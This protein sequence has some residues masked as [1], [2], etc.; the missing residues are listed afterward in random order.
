[1]IVKPT[2]V[3]SKKLERDTLIED[4]N[5][6]STVR[7]RSD[8]LKKDRKAAGFTQYAFSAACRSVSLSTVRRAEQGYRVTEPAAKKMAH[9]LDQPTNRYIIK[10]DDGSRADYVA[11][12]A[13]DWTCFHVDAEQNA[14]PRLALSEMCIRQSGG[15]IVGEIVNT[16]SEN[17]IAVETFKAEVIN[18]VV[19]GRAFHLGD[20]VSSG[21][22][23]ICCLA[24]RNDG[25]L[26]GYFS[27]INQNGDSVECMR[28]IAVRNRIPNFDQYVLE[29]KLIADREISLIHVKKLLEAGYEIDDA[30]VMLAALKADLHLVSR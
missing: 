23:A 8:V 19:S 11:W 20:D 13:G 9:I 3:I 25:W 15:Q 17:R 5:P 16:T 10:P 14:S 4:N 21:V 18:N 28:F 2:Q 26:D 7:I 29:A 27:R 22:G 24:K 1:M 6:H 12:L 30:I